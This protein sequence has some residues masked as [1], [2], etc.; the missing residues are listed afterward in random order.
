[1]T[2]IFTHMDEALD[3][4]VALSNAGRTYRYTRNAKGEHEITTRD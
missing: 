4:A 3:C 2:M 1:M